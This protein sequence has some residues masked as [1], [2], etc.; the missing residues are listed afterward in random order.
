[1]VIAAIV[2][3]T[4]FIRHPIQ[5]EGLFELILHAISEFFTGLW[6]LLAAEKAKGVASFQKYA[7]D[8]NAQIA[9]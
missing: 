9:E 8:E 6:S 4:F 1:L 3:G 2:I 7:E 5:Q